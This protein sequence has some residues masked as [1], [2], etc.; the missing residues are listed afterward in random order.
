MAEERVDEILYVDR[1]HPQASDQN[2][3]NQILPFR[4]I[5]KAAAVA[6]ANN[7][8]NVGTKILIAAGIY[9]ETIDLPKTGRETEAP[10]IFEAAGEVI[11]SGSDVWTGWQRATGDNV[12]V[13]AWPYRW[14]LP[15]GSPT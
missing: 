1:S 6:A 14:G 8:R 10:I 3:G 9:R 5:S 2:S 7:S 12:W 13:H 4:T 11:V 15:A